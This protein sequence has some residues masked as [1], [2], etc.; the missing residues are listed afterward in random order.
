MELF[1]IEIKKLIIVG[2]LFISTNL[3]SQIGSTIMFENPDS[4]IENYVL[5]KINFDVSRYEMWSK[6]SK[7]HTSFDDFKMINN[8]STIKY[9]GYKIEPNLNIE[10]K[11]K[12]K[13]YIVYYYTTDN[14]TIKGLW[15]LELDS[16]FWYITSNQSS[17]KKGWESFRNENYLDAIKYFKQA[18][19][20]DPYDATSYNYLAKIYFYLTNKDS[21]FSNSLIAENAKLA[22]KYEPDNS[23][24]YCTMG[25]YFSSLKSYNLS[26]HYYLK[27]LDFAKKTNELSLI[28][29]NLSS[30]YF[31]NEDTVNCKKYAELS[32]R[33][34]STDEFAFYILGK[35]NF[36]YNSFLIA[37][38]YFEKSINSKN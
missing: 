21:T 24:N 29:S 37:K 16:N 13:N 38:F 19:E 9:K 20:I 10:P 34:D 11:G 14:D 30:M 31:E 26:I 32:I 28:Y 2:I 35:L 15:T 5:K 12:Y 27:A 3:F 17:I 25:S 7:K 8:D 33:T 36:K 4:C 23:D 6:L 22:I 1:R 18:I